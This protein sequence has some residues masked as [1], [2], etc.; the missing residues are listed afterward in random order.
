MVE[1]KSAKRGYM[2]PK[3]ISAHL[4]KFNSTSD[5]LDYLDDVWKKRNLLSE[6]T[7]H[8]V[9]DIY[10]DLCNNKIKHYRASGI[11]NRWFPNFIG[12]FKGEKLDEYESNLRYRHGSR[13]FVE[14]GRLF[15]REGDLAHDIGYL[16]NAKK[17]YNNAAKFVKKGNEEFKRESPSFTSEEHS[18]EKKIKVVNDEIREKHRLRRSALRR[19]ALSTSI[20]GIFAGLFFLSSNITGNVIGLNQTPSNWIGGVLFLIGLVGALAYFKGR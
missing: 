3:E 14:A 10:V 18:I 2:T 4:N 7:R 1:K 17:L 9:Y 11:V 15:K 12:L 13:D 5:K 6:E 19:A 8:S 20:L 16:E